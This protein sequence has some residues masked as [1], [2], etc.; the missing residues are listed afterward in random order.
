MFEYAG[1]VVRCGY[2]GVVGVNEVIV[3]VVVVVVGIWWLVSCGLQ[4]S[5]VVI[6]AV[7][8]AT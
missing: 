5:Y 8:V 6:L 1:G 4:V 3:D 7:I 2:V